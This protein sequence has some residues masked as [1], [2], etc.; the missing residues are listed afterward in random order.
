M[1]EEKKETGCFPVGFHSG[2]GR[3]IR[4]HVQKFIVPNLVLN[5]II[6]FRIVE[7]RYQSV[8]ANQNSFSYKRSVLRSLVCVLQDVFFVCSILNNIV[9]TCRKSSKQACILIIMVIRNICLLLIFFLSNSIIFLLTCNLTIQI[10][11]LSLKKMKGLD[12]HG[13]LSF[14]IQMA[15]G[16][17]FSSQTD[18]CRKCL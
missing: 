15:Q 3:W 7:L 12:A 1:K 6:L 14:T 2:R 4:N 8:P 11:I 17:H 18:S 9:C 13:C 5:N 10:N 16:R